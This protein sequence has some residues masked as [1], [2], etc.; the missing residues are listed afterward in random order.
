VAYYANLADGSRVLVRFLPTLH[1]REQFGGSWDNSNNWTLGITHS[2][3]HGVLIDPQFG[4]NVTGPAGN[5]TI[6]SLLVAGN[7]GNA[8][9]DLNAGGQLSV[10]GVTTVKSTGSIS[11]GSGKLVGGSLVNDGYL[12][13]AVGGQLPMSTITNNNNINLSWPTLTS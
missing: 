13:V 9:L 5:V 1:W 4:A 12:S 8:S 6:S 7:S 3:V 10:S 11:V 2:S